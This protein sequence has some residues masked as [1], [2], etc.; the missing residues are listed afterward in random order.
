MLPVW[1][2]SLLLRDWLEKFFWIHGNSKTL[3]PYPE[4]HFF[5]KKVAIT[6]LS[7]TF[8]T[9]K[10]NVKNAAL[11]L[12]IIVAELMFIQNWETIILKDHKDTHTPHACFPGLHCSYV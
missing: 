10:E 6:V 12:K 1:K 8:E 11:F 2:H 7:T 5:F 4:Q 3:Q 9:H